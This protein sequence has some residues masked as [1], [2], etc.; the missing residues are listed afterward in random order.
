MAIEG[1]LASLIE[2]K[3]GRGREG[4]MEG[5]ARR[6]ERTREVSTRA[7]HGEHA[8]HDLQ[9]E[10]AEKAWCGKSSRIS[11][12]VHVCVDGHSACCGRNRKSETALETPY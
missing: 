11:F 6:E 2:G 1:A 8:V 9:L 12:L 3:G 4:G 5:E 10:V 7:Q